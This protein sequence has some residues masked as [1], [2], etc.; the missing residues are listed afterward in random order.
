MDI[1]HTR[2]LSCIFQILPVVAF[3]RYL[4]NRQLWP[5]LLLLFAA[6]MGMAGPALP[7]GGGAPPVAVRPMKNKSLTA[8]ASLSGCSQDTIPPTVSCQN[9]TVTLDAGGSGWLDS[10][11][12]V[13]AA[14][15]NCGIP[16]VIFSKTTFD[17]SE[18]VYTAY[19]DQS[20]PPGSDQSAANGI[21]Q[22]FV[23]GKSGQL[24]SLRINFA[25]STPF[26]GDIIIYRGPDPNTGQVI[27]TTQFTF[28]LATGPA[29]TLNLSLPPTVHAGDTLTFVLDDLML[30]GNVLG[31]FASGNP[32]PSGQAWVNNSGTWVA[33]T[34][35]DLGFESFVTQS[36]AT[37][38]VTVTVADSV[39]NLDSCTALIALRDPLPP[40]LNCP[41]DKVVA[42]SGTKCKG[43]VN[44]IAPLSA[45]DNCTVQDT[46]WTFQ[47]A[48]NLAG[49][50]DASGYYMFSGV[51]AVQYIVRDS[52]TH[53]DT[54]TF[55]VTVNDSTPPLASCYGSEQTDQNQD[56]YDAT[57]IISNGFAQT[58]QAGITGTLTKVELAFSHSGFANALVE[59][60][61]GSNPA[62]GTVL[63][64]TNQ[65]TTNAMTDFII[66]IP[67]TPI[68]TAGANYL[69]RVSD[70]GGPGSFGV[71]E[72]NTNPYPNGSEW[73]L[74]GS[75]NQD[76]GADLAFTTY[77]IPTDTIAT[78]LYL[79]ASGKAPVPAGILNNASSD[80]CGIDTLWAFPDTAQCQHTGISPVQ[81]V[82][83]DQFGNRDS[84]TTHIR[85]LD[86][87]PPTALCQN[88]TIYLDA[89]G[90]AQTS[91]NAIDNGS[92]DN[93]GL[94]SSWLD[95]S[96]ITCTEI[97]AH[98][99]TLTVADP[100]GYPAQCQAQVTVLDTAAPLASCQPQT[101][102]LD[103]S[104]NASTQAAWINNG[105]TDVCGLLQVE[106][107]DSLFNCMDVGVNTL[108]LTATDLSGNQ[109]TCHAY[110]TLSDTTAPQALCQDLT[111][112]LQPNDTAFL[113][114]SAV[115]NGSTDNC[116][117]LLQI[118]L[119][120]TAFPCGTFSPQQ[121]TL[122]A[123]DPSGN[124]DTCQAWITIL[125]TAGNCCQGA[126]VASMAASD[127]VCPGANAYFAVNSL[128]GTPDSLRWQV[129]TDN[130]LTWT[131]VPDISASYDSASTDTLLLINIPPGF[132]G[133]QYRLL[134]YACG[135]LSDSSATFTLE[136][137]T[138]TPVFTLCPVLLVTPS[139]SGS[140]GA[141]V[142][143]PSP[144][145]TAS[146][147][148][149]SLVLVTGLASGST[150]SAGSHT[151]LWVASSGA[152]KD[153]CTFSITVEDQEVPSI[154]C[155]SDTIIPND[156]GLC[157]AVFSYT[158]PVGTD[159]CP[160]ASTYLNTGQ[161]PGTAFNQGANLETWKITDSAGNVDSCSFT[162]TVAEQE[163]PLILC[164]PDTV[165]PNDPGNCTAVFTFT[166][167]IGTD[168]CGGATTT[169]NAGLGS[170]A[171]FPGGITLQTFVTTDASGNQDSCSFTVTVTDG[172]PPQII[173]PSDITVGND[174]GFCTA[175]VN[176]AAPAG[177][178][179]CPGTVTALTA[180]QGPG[181]SFANGVNLEKYLVTD[182]SSKVDSCEFT[183][184][185]EDAESPQITCPADLT[186]ANDPGI[187][188]AV[189]NYTAPT[190]LDNCAL[191]TTLLLSGNSP[192]STFPAGTHPITW[193]TVDQEGNTAACT[194][195]L[196]VQD[197]QPPVLNCPPNLTVSNDPGQCSAVVNYPVPTGV[198]NCGSTV[199]L[200]TA[201]LGSGSPFPKGIT[202]EIYTASDSSGNQDNCAFTIT[203]TDNEPPQLTCPADLTV[204]NDP[205]QCGAV[206]SYSG[207]WSGDNCGIAGLSQTSG[208]GS[209]SSFA[210]GSTRESYLAVDSAGNTDTCSF[211]ITVRDNESPLPACQNITVYLNAAG[212]VSLSPQQVDNGTSDNCGLDSL[213]IIPTTFT[214]QN[215]GAASVT[216]MAKD[217]QGNADSCTATVWVTDTV[218]PL[219][220]GCPG[221]TTLQSG[222]GN[223]VT[224]YTWPVPSVADNCGASLSS[225]YSPGDSFW[226]GSTQVI[227]L[228]TDLAGNS[229]SCLFTI[230]V[231]P[232]PLLINATAPT[233]ACGYQI[234][235]NG[236]SDGRASVSISGGC[237]PYTINWSNGSLTDSISAIPAGTYTVTVID[238]LGSSATDT[239]TLF[240]PP[241]IILN[242]GGT[243]LV[244]E[245]DSTAAP[246]LTV[247]GGNACLGYS[248]AWSN[249]ATVEDP[250]NLPA[251]M[252]SVTVT[253]SGG[254][255]TTDTLFVQTF[256][257]EILNL[258]NDT[259]ICPGATLALDAGDPAFQSWQWTSS[260]TTP[261]IIV[262]LP[263]SYQ[264]TA[265][266]TNGCKASDSL[267][268]WIAAPVVVD[269]GPDTTL[270][271]GSSL[272]TWGGSFASYRWSTGDSTPG[273]WA[274]LAGI[275]Y[276]DAWD[277]LGC[278]G[279]DTMILGIYQV[280]PSSIAAA[281]VLC[282]H[283]DVH[284]TANPGFLSYL[285]DN[286]DTTAATL[287]TTR[288]Y[289]TVTVGDGSGCLRT[290]S[291]YVDSLPF[292]DP[293][294]AVFPGGTLYICAGT[295]L[296]LDVGEHGGSHIW[297]TGDSTRK[298]L[299]T[300]PGTYFA[301]VANGLGCSAYSD[302]VTVLGDT[303]VSP[304][305][306][307]TVSGPDTLLNAFPQDTSYT[308]QWYGYTPAGGAADTLIPGAT[309]AVYQ[310]TLPGCYL[311][312]IITQ[313][314]C[315]ALSDTFCLLI[316][317]LEE[318]VMPPGGIMVFPNPTRDYLTLRTLNP[319]DQ[320]LVLRLTDM[321]GQIVKHD[322]LNH[323]T[324]DLVLDL[325]RFAQGFYVLEVELEDGGRHVWGVV[326][327]D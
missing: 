266:D 306:T 271:D 309:G 49:T 189:V 67:S 148:L 253:D 176:Y 137:G 262:S 32:Y 181:S 5:G 252:Y 221:D 95:D 171:T 288:G 317:G 324:H 165:L 42:V 14:S 214:C 133:N 246:D 261:Q 35:F 319:I 162:I 92:Y 88:V 283:D 320:P 73:Q 79:N 302:T 259:T 85:V 114:S 124:Q 244:C 4:K 160:G 13:A 16:W 239:L 265:T 213:W 115:N 275:Y 185:V 179:N 257:V 154:L 184:T 222:P 24:T 187:C 159:N 314:G 37:I 18:L 47:G 237:S 260:D 51:T 230:T 12:V 17:C 255:Q 199:T 210:T 191:D 77:L 152:A 103:A 258:G 108:I 144:A 197:T 268:V 72:N 53:S 2:T 270:C 157:T 3:R 249:G 292:D 182:A 135:A 121:I 139:D 19:S 150:F 21:G 186:V 39:G 303:A 107:D 243:L 38:P 6:T 81:L 277:S 174:P 130:G 146:C 240:S 127:T 287:V 272:W 93:C 322:Y 31:S 318:P 82:I 267:L 56:T 254:C 235:C 120:D 211:T 219:I 8:A 36:S 310:P 147:G 256:P 250:A 61:T 215:A 311:V 106:L 205:G 233:F 208:P 273:I 105:S 129:S 28:P 29:T 145:A 264:V 304:F 168:N 192:G 209:G 76:L 22:T 245:G 1:L 194:F 172:E 89:G 65:A 99:V 282:N 109:D 236:Q 75:W 216:L 141:V 299:V 206:V 80:H 55:T 263:G 112:Y 44:A 289:H 173:C 125:D 101:L 134:V 26:P 20:S 40:V 166:P 248:Y 327:G 58:F 278:S 41:P 170:G 87:L 132:S 227:C 296:V 180:G 207:P 54:C 308:Y 326:L 312:E 217:L 50:G 323:L 96:T 43:K 201:A 229:D 11:K 228:G 33:L 164:P 59:I 151:L 113:S 66:P 178:D 321:Y 126:W 188:G 163:I 123:A 276:L 122:T 98:T 247:S 313:G 294:P 110:L 131:S 193:Q 242:F 91:S 202:T 70:G 251:G 128:S 15:D 200:P 305:I 298:L 220:S 149:D 198:D 231:I 69:V 234:S 74:G 57:L 78:T 116:A 295:T 224:G 118:S 167:P 285:W 195:N 196:T 290:D 71:L 155:P 280:A 111:I 225:N 218:A 293:N 46:F 232:P 117:S 307:Q 223:C 315:A 25:H 241:P 183:I 83:S 238:S 274:G 142:T 7:P 102:Y 136:V 158:P 204:S 34:G 269:L 27:A 156:S 138:T 68:L 300:H 291:I 153:S 9:D 62:A 161:G 212:V 10:A 52:S 301:L 226:V 177:T 279:S 175:V 297:N 48:T 286:G 203:V 90:N 86:T 63:A 284:L 190:G 30:P 140:C 104:G 97:G 325:T 281:G 100:E 64:S 316:T 143:Y 119:S 60:V 23:V 94:S 169:Q 84:C 45:T